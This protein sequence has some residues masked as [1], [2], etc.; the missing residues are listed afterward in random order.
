VDMLICAAA[1]RHD[2][3]VFTVDRDFERYARALPVRL[4]R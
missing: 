4:L 2:V 1:V 3:A